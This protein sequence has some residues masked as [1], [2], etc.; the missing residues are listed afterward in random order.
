MRYFYLILFIISA[1]I[2]S[3]HSSNKNTKKINTNIEN[4][5][6]EFRWVQLKQP[7]FQTV[8][9]EP[10]TLRRFEARNFD[11]PEFLWNSG[12]PESVYYLQ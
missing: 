3:L 4:E 1:S 6:T 11:T 5:M 8:N 7:D 2:L 9:L 10:L 12:T